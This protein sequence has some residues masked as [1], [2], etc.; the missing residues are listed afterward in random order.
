MR[1]FMTGATGVIGRRALPQLVQR[2]AVTVALHTE[3][4][5]KVIEATGAQCAVVDLFDPAGLER[6]M[7]GHDTVINLATHIPSSAFKMMFKRNWEENHRIRTAGVRNLVDVAIA[8]GVT[9]FLQESFAPAYPDCGDEWIDESTPLDPP[10]F[11]RSIV[12]A[13]AAVT[14]LAEANRTGV[15]LRFALFYGPDSQQLKTFVRAIKLGFAPIPGDPRA[16][17]STVSH[18]DAARAVVAA[19]NA[20]S[21]AYNIS[22]DQP[23]RR[24]ECFAE[25]AHA[26]GVDPPRFLPRWTQRMFGPSAEMMARSIRM[27]NRKFRAETGWHPLLPSM[28][29]GWRATLQPAPRGPIRAPA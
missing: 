10:P 29:E 22:D 4:A 23:L 17:I 28:H 7:T 12:E 13:E 25:L 24:G 11:H 6:A 27:S 18:D 8:C 9:R 1:I 16:Y 5:R 20:H 21:G 14:E 2:H 26:I 15:I 3:S 19:L